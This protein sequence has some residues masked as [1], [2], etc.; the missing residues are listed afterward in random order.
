MDDDYLTDI[1]PDTTDINC[2]NS[3]LKDWEE[4]WCMSSV[5]GGEYLSKTNNAL[6]NIEQRG[7]DCAAI[8]QKGK[9]LLNEYGLRY[10]PGG[11]F[12]FG[13]RGHPSMGV[14][15]DELWLN[16]YG[17]NT[18]KMTDVDGSEIK[19]NLEYGLVHEIEHAMG[20]N[21]IILPNGQESEL[22]TLHAIECSG[23]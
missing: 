11:N 14:L 12:S 21:H 10:Y 6:D 9:Q 8:A 17:D 3:D 18:V 7:S 5:P 15:L 4:A 2:N 13:G 16:Y 20:K 22:I 23:L 1:D 19:V